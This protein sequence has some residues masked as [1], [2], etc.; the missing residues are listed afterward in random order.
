MSTFKEK[1]SAI[2]EEEN[3][4]LL[5]RESTI[6]EGKKIVLMK[7]GD[8]SV[9]I[10]IEEVKSLMQI[11]ENHL[12]H[13]IVKLT[14]FNQS[15]R[16]DKTKMPCD[17]YVYDEHFYF[18]KADLT[19]EQLDSS[20]IIIEV[21]DSSNSRKRR[22]F[23]GIYEF[24]LEYIYSMKN[25]VLKNHWLALS[26]PESKDMTKIRGYLKLSI[27]VLHD[28]DPRVELKSNPDSINCFIPSQIKVE[29][30]QLSIYLM[31]VEEVPDMD[32]TFAL[33]K[34]DR[35]ADPYVE[36]NYFGMKIS[37]KYVKN[38]NDVSIWNQLINLPIQIPYVSQKIVMLVR[39]HDETFTDDNIGS[40]EIDLNDITGRINKYKDFRY[41]DIYGSSRNKKV[42]ISNLMNQNAEIGSSWNGRI[43]LKI[44]YKTTDTPITSVEDLDEKKYG[45]II[46][47][48]HSL[49]RNIKWVIKAKLY[50]ASYLPK[51]FK[52]YKLKICMQDAYYEFDQKKAVNEFIEW[53]KVGTFEFSSLS[54]EKEQ[55]PDMFFYLLNEKDIPVCFQRIKSTSFH[56]NEQIMIIKL[57]P[58]PCYDEVKSNI[59]SGLLKVKICLYNKSS[60][61]D[62]VDLTKFQDGESEDENKKEDNLLANAAFGGIGQT[63]KDL[64]TVVCV[65]YMSRYLISKDSSGN[66]DPYVRITCVNDKKETSP[67]HET[68]NGIW[69]EMLVFDGVQLDLKK[70]STWPILLAEVCDK[71]DLLGYSYIWLGDSPYK[72]NETTEMK[73]KWHQLYLQKSN[74]PQGELLLAFYIFD[75]TPENKYKFRNIQPVPK[76]KPYT[77]EINILG[78][79]D[80]KPLTMLP[81]KKAYIKFDMNSLNVSGEEKNNLPSKVTQPKDKGSNPT[82]NSAL[83]FEI[84][85]PINDIFMP[86]LQCQVFDYIYSGLLNPNL[87]LFLLNIKKLIDQTKKQID[88]DLKNTKAKLAYYMSAG[89]VKN[90]LGHIGGLDKLFEKNKNNN[91]N[92]INT[93]SSNDNIINTSSSSNKIND[94]NNNINEIEKSEEEIAKMRAQK[95]I[96][97]NT[98]NYDAQFVEKNKDI[99]EYFVLLPQYQ[100]Y[101]IPGSSKHKG[102]KT[103]YQKEDLTL[104]P[105]QDYY[106]AIGYIP[107]YVYSKEKNPEE[108][109]NENEKENEEKKVEEDQGKIYNIK[110][111]YRRYYRTEL[112]QVKELNIKS[113]F[114]I[115]YIRRGKDKDIK[116]ETAIFSALSNEKNKILKSYDP[117]DDNLSWEEKE[118]IK[119]NKKRNQLFFG[120]LLQKQ[121]TD[122]DILPRNLMDRGFGKFKSV[123]RVCDK[124]TMDKF[125]KEIEGFKSRDER[126]MKELKNVEKYEKLTKSILVKHEVIIRVYI[127][128]IHDLPAKDLL[129][130]SDPY[131]KI[132]FGEEKKY[133]EVKLHQD[134]TNNVK[135]YKYYDIRSIFPGESTLK[136]EVWDYN[137]IFKDVLIGS[138]SL[139]LEDRYFNNEWQ[140]L[141]F[142][143]IETRQLTH[144]DITGQ[145]G[146]ITLWVEIFEK[147]DSLN[148]T[149]WQIAPEPLSQVEL[150]LVVWETE[151]MRMMDVED[152]SDIYVTAFV[153]QK[154]KQS[155]DTHYR[156]QTGNASFNWRIVLPIEV[157]RKNNKLTL[158]C[159]DK[160]IFSR[161]DFISGAE[162]ELK[163]LI[164]IPKDLDAPITFS[165]SY[166]DSVSEEEKL[167]YEGIEF[168]EGGDDEEKNKFWVQCYH[169]NIKSGRIL[170]SLEI[171]PMWK[172]EANKV[173]LGRKEPNYSPY[174]PPPVGRFQ[175]SWNP[176]TMFN[177]CIGPRFRKK[178]YKGCAICCCIVY[179]IFLIP[180]IIYHLSG[181]IVN[182]F[183]YV[184]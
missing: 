137:P 35:P 119:K 131:I 136:I 37:S 135:W 69:N 103:G 96:T 65:V 95:E 164:N 107:K 11:S 183:N 43:L 74:S 171:L 138:T 181:Q 100:T 167:L 88:E 5:R 104:A 124:E 48:A 16:T 87:G 114:Y 84:N 8:Y 159:Y 50:N 66:N 27:S 102:N 22:D 45:D 61:F 162:I 177:Q 73:P 152:T 46:K 132:Y 165:K 174:L 111:H 161:D 82:I 160:D 26:N 39:D 94:N 86:Q 166:L 98:K 149:P 60:E 146:Y 130:E 71:N 115:A 49:K 129:S 7:K 47:E 17:S 150:R 172:A 148:L 80:I 77:F 10:L 64:Y 127:L 58:E 178:I 110:K 106:Q 109:E 1:D 41:I 44:D 2:N 180:Y 139:D 157:P 30:R 92:I 83:K 108:R 67:K 53:N 156:C 36:F 40:Y 52:K 122:S 105:S 113:P 182:P 179:L 153:D 133:D 3:Q 54:E 154:N 72:I 6:D 126:V 4:E 23:F 125:Q 42:A 170:C 24:D 63:L 93:N 176:F 116:D 144:P 117:K 163:H 19:V 169:K 118:K 121:M 147:S 151:D 128:E 13:P 175:W 34:K 75:Q 78:L 120:E 57:F 168:L 70:K 21:F 68:I 51:Q 79:R 25:H 28:N 38:K 140:Q 33:E 91:E 85:L 55:L 158:H 123:I 89:I 134:D 20:K 9:H 81:I 112:E 101:F 59:N 29:Y 99:S 90:A 155:T 32:S 173:G 62:Q 143:P 141:K 76:T 18:D 56:L 15:K 14:V 142:K 145:Q 97:V 12:P 31:K 184:K